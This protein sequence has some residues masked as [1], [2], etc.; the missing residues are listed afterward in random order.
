M[1]L[2][3]SGK[4]RRQQKKN[5]EAKLVLTVFKLH[6]QLNKIAKMTIENGASKQEGKMGNTIGI[7][8]SDACTHTHTHPQ[9][10]V[11]S[12]FSEG[13]EAHTKVKQK[14]RPK[15]YQVNDA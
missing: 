6:G 4:R 14:Y 12:A 15:V 1:D 7:N 3:I 10:L 8:I 13:C 9:C 5:C 11:F 2:G